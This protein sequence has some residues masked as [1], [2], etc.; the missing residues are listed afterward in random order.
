MAHLKG[1]PKDPVFQLKELADEAKNELVSNIY[2]MDNDVN[3]QFLGVQSPEFKRYLE[4]MGHLQEMLMKASGK[5][6]EISEY[7]QNVI[8]WISD[9]SEV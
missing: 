9:F 3:S 2:R 5:M 6:N 8:D 1:L 4:L 7:C